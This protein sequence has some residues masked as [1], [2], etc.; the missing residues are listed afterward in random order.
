MWLCNPNNPTGTMFTEDELLDFLKSIPNNI[1]V[2]YDEAY[3]EY[4]TRDDY[5]KNSIKFL[6]DY[7]I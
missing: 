3:N 6:K 7:L 5:P 1:V 4:V 2:V